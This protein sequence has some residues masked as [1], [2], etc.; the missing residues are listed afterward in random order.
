MNEI[1]I[2]STGGVIAMCAVAVAIVGPYAIRELYRERKALRGQFAFGL[3]VLFFGIAGR[4]GAA[5][6]FYYTPPAGRVEMLATLHPWIL[7]ANG[8]IALGA[9]LCI[10]LV[11]AHRGEWPWIAAVVLS[12]LAAF[13]VTR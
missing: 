7:T 8:L 5:W 3:T 10:R 13:A 1:Q 2:W 11:T 9:V 12:A 6:V 4:L